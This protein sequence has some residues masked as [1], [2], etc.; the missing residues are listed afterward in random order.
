[1]MNHRDLQ[2]TLQKDILISNVCGT[3]VLS[4]W[5]TLLIGFGSVWIFSRL[6]SNGRLITSN[7][8]KADLPPKTFKEPFL[9]FSTYLVLAP[10]LMDT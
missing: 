4:V 3:Y 7:Q 1:M 8:D 10:R 5:F 2:D 6:I 9:F